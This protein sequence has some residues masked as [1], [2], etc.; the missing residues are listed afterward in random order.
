[1]GESGTEKESK[2]NR[3]NNSTKA[4]QVARNTMSVYVLNTPRRIC[5]RKKRTQLS[6]SGSRYSNPGRMNIMVRFCCSDADSTISYVNAQ[7]T[8]CY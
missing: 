2:R 6:C 4:Q 3:T 8:H 5:V 1:M 7:K